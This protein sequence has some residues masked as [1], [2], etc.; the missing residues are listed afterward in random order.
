MTTASVDATTGVAEGGAGAVTVTVNGVGMAITEDDIA[1]YLQDRKLADDEDIKPGLEVDSETLAAIFADKMKSSTF[2]DGTYEWDVRA[3][4]ESLVFEF[5]SNNTTPTQ[6]L[7]K[8]YDTSITRLSGTT[9]D[10]TGGKFTSGAYTAGVATG[11]AAS[12]ADTQISVT[13]KIGGKN[14]TFTGTAGAAV[15]AAGLATAVGNATATIDGKTVKLSDYFNVADEGNDGTV[16]IESIATGKEGSDSI[17][18]FTA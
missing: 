10:A 4:G 12:V 1:K 7:N 14:V 16:D 17:E 18:K 13:A 8:H 6:T 9:V 3:D 5:S 11:G 2:N 15:T